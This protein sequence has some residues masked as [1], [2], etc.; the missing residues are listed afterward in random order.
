MK[1]NSAPK[2][3]TKGFLLKVMPSLDCLNEAIALDGQCDPRNCWHYVGINKKMDEIAPGER[4]QVKVDAGHIKVNYHGWRYVADT[5]RHV[6]RSLMLFDKGHYEA[7]RVREYSLRFRRTT[8]IIE[9]DNSSPERKAQI[10]AARRKRIAEGKPD[11]V[12][13]LRKR[14]E[15][16]SAIV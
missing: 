7:L 8:K 12:Y 13:N 9:Q 16:F 5:P 10:N 3:A 4:H 6:K 11:K 2:Q 1:S 14:V 15:G